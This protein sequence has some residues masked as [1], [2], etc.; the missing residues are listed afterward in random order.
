MKFSSLLKTSGLFVAALSFVQCSSSTKTTATTGTAPPDSGTASAGC[1][2]YCDAIMTNCTG[3]ETP[4]TN[5]QYLTKADCIAVCSAF[6]VGTSSDTSGNTLGCRTYHAHLAGSDAS[7]A[8]VTH[9]PHAGPGGDGVCSSS[10]ADFCDEYCQ[11]VDKFCVGTYS[12]YSSQGDCL[13][14]CKATPATGHFTISTSIQAS[15]GQ[16]CLL[17]HAQEAAVDPTRCTDDL[18]KQTADAGTGGSVTCH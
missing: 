10:S 4:G 16:S 8:A 14:T 18:S 2:A 12:I 1:Q 3:G 15:D 5:Q 17:F 11:I 6:P 7:N 9:C 13:T